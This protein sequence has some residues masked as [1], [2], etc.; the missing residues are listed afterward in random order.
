MSATQQK[1][2]LPARREE[3]TRDCP[4]SLPQEVALRYFTHEKKQNGLILRF[5]LW[6]KKVDNAIFVTWDHRAKLDM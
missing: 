4:G 1:L 3:A 5:P 6:R 2:T